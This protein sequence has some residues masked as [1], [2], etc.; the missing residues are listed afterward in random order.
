MVKI[1]S[2]LTRENLIKVNTYRPGAQTSGGGGQPVDPIPTTIKKSMYM[3]LEKLSGGQAQR[4][5]GDQ[6]KAKWRATVDSDAN[7]LENDLIEIISGPYSGTILQVEDVR[8][9][10]NF[11]MILPLTDTEKTVS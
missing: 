5:F 7:I 1:L 11:L 10:N 6:S 3:K 4:D 9:P 8:V 2:V